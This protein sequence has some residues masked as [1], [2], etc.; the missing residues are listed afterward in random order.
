MPDDFLNLREAFSGMSGGDTLVI[1]DGVYTGSSNMIIN[2]N[3][4]PVGS[5]NNY[6][7]IKAEH[8]GK[9]IF[10][11]QNN[12]ITFYVNGNGQAKYW[13]FDGLVWRNSSTDGNVVLLQCSYVKFLRC[14]AYNCLGFAQNFANTE[15]SYILYE[16]CFAFGTGGRYKFSSYKSD[17]IIYRRC[18]G[19]V[20][21]VNTN[22]SG[23]LE[24]LGVFVFYSTSNSYA[25]N[26]I[27]IDS[28]H[29]E[30]WNTLG[31]IGAFTVPNGSGFN[32]NFTG[33]VGLNLDL[34]SS[35]VTSGF[36]NVHYKNCTFARYNTSGLKRGS[37]DF[38]HCA[39]VNSDDRGN[40]QFEGK[41]TVKNSIIYGNVSSG[42]SG[43]F[44]SDYNCFYNN[45][46]NY[47]GVTPGPHDITDINP[48]NNAFK[49]LVRIK[50]N[51][52]LSAKAS[53]TGDIGPNI[54]KQIGRSGTLW[55]EEGFDAVQD[56][57][58]GQQD[59]D[60]W[61]FP[62]E[63]VI[64][65]YMRAY[66]GAVI[67][68]KR[69]FC[70]DG[71]TL[72]KYIWEYLGNSCP[73]DICGGTPDPGNSPPSADAGLDQS[74][75]DTDGNGNEQI[76]LDGSGSSD[77]DGY[78]ISY[79]WW[80]NGTQIATGI[81]PSVALNVGTHN[82]TL[83]VQD[84]DRATASDI[85]Q[86]TV[87]SP[88]DTTPP[89]ITAVQSTGI[90][91]TTANISWATDEPADSKVEFG[92]TQDYGKE[93]SDQALVTNHNVILTGLS[94]ST[95]YNYLVE[96]TDANGNLASSS[97]YTFTTLEQGPVEMH[98]LQDF[99]DGVVWLP[100]GPQ[101]PTGNGRGWA[102]THPG[103]PGDRI[104]I[105]NIGANGSKHSLK[106]TFSGVDN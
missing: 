33:C 17:H 106:I 16:S 74:M 93:N 103:D 75:T 102:F 89:T 39:F 50:S 95:T 92:V 88:S 59:L 77:S 6:T 37:D 11:G 80:E 62:Y 1:R 43:V 60:L 48:L 73:A 90:T 91:A 49:Y 55:G 85:V 27:A 79:S 97:N 21:E 10:D 35:V 98:T 28:D 40:F 58:N 4:P 65:G 71:Q 46:K 20:D 94:P 72:T 86:I 42:L 101:D 61:P 23:R 56:G 30:V 51:S 36:T 54:V 26:C 31:V 44:T 3:Y 99:E 25:Q 14:G 81:N 82:I 34:D 47:D 100:G 78:I 52:D 29:S 41:G 19:R 7:I 8:P 63:T 70:A 22:H 87:N 45:G 5:P 64:R 38:D 84:N 2:N 53:D 12:Y 13:Q 105:D 96:S 24:P 76:T 66:T 9:V 67:S 57:T 18:V 32:I 83:R 68:G 104:E 69:G 15:S